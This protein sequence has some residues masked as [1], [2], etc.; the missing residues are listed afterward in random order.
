MISGETKT[1]IFFISSSPYYGFLSN[2]Y[3]C[4]FIDD[5]EFNNTNQQIVFKNMEQYFMYQKAKMFDQTM[6]NKILNEEKPREIQKFG[7]Q[8][9]NFN[10]DEWDKHKYDIMEKVYH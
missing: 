5:D 3:P 4:E 9:N 7:R 2:F 1:S 6:I 8:I 10:P